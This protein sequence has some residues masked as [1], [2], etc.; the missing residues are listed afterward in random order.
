MSALLDLIPRWALAA[1]I[2]ML[3]ATSCKLKWDNGQLSIEIEKG[4]TNVAQLRTQIAATEEAAAKQHA[5]QVERARAAEHDRDTRIRQAD[6]AFAAL[7]TERERLRDALNSY[8]ASRLRASPA[9]LAPVLDTADPLAELFLQC[10]GRY[11]D[12]ARAADGHV[13]DIQALIQAW[14][15]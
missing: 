8:T 1:A 15:R 14:P 7:R 9:S 3:V 2:A 6:I 11:A 12:L 13:N 4:K 10:T 5:E